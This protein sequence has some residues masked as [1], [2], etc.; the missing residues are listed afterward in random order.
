[1]ENVLQELVNPEKVRAFVEKANDGVSLGYHDLTRMQSKQLQ[2]CS[3]LY[4]NF[5]T[6]HVGV[7]L[8]EKFPETINA[9]LDGIVNYQR[10]E[11][12]ALGVLS[13]GDPSLTVVTPN[14]LSQ[15]ITNYARDRNRLYQ[16]LM[17]KFGES[18]ILSS[19]ELQEAMIM[20]MGNL[21]LFREPAMS[22]VRV[23]Y[24]GVIGAAIESLNGSG[25]H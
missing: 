16:L 10:G 3:D 17:Q 22:L 7:Q 4:K 6:R 8:G 23:A 18:E 24:A 21:R 15:V 11:A 5:F 13:G 1:M 12:I 9:S 14:G 19:G 2:P 20:I 25:K